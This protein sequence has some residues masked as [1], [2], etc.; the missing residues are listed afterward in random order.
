[1]YRERKWE[2]GRERLGGEE[3]GCKCECE[4]EGGTEDREG[5][6][7]GGTNR[8]RGTGRERGREGQEGREGEGQG[9]G[10]RQGVGEGQGGRE[11]QDIARQGLVLGGIEGGVELDDRVL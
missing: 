6:R 4:L 3:S 5:G 11:G 7:E 9:V 10:E 2:G 8:E 1:L